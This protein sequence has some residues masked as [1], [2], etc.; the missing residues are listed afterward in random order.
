[1]GEPDTWCH[2]MVTVR[3]K[4]KP[5]RTVD[6]QVFNKHGVRETHHTQSPFHQTKLVPPGT[7]KTITDAWYHIV[8][9][10]EGDRHLTTFMMAGSVSIQ[11]L[12]TMLRCIPVRVHQ[13]I[14]RHCQGFSLQDQMHQ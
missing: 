5:R 3:K 8:S 13:K 2:R 11:T 1:M 9:V 10:R 7:K 6:M 4:G 12:C 14:R